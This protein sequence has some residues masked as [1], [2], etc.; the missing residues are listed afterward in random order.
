MIMIIVVQ[1]ANNLKTFVPD[2]RSGT[3]ES[4]V[5]QWASDYPNDLLDRWAWCYLDSVEQWSTD[6]KL[7]EDVRLKSVKVL[8]DSERQTLVPLDDKIAEAI[9]KQTTPLKETYQAVGDGLKVTE[10]T[11]PTEIR[12]PDPPEPQPKPQPPNRRRI[13]RR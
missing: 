3:F 12:P 2:F 1:T 5:R 7:R 6:Q 13:F 8:T 11:P 10:W 9:P 4:Q